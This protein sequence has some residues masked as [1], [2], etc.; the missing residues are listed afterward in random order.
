MVG[1]IDH[2]QI[3]SHMKS[4]LNVFDKSNIIST[5]VRD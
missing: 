1:S 4:K 3:V 2:F 5:I